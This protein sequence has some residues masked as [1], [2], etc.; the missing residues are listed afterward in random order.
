[1]NIIM[2]AHCKRIPSIAEIPS[3]LNSY[4]TSNTSI[5]STLLKYVTLP[6]AE[7]SAQPK[8][9][10][11]AVKILLAPQ[12][13]V[14]AILFEKDKDDEIYAYIYEQSRE[15]SK[16]MS[17]FTGI[18]DT[19]SINWDFGGSIILTVSAKELGLQVLNIPI[20][21]DQLED[22]LASGKLYN[23]GKIGT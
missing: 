13:V 5:D 2:I 7:Q 20:S 22:L 14:R 8:T 10:I 18:E 23:M 1:M 19:M 4:A 21:G 3:S 12:N 16:A 9:S 17:E 15:I 6:N 11:R